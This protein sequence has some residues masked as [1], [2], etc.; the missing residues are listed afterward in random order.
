MQI[1]LIAMSTLL[2]SAARWIISWHPKQALA[3]SVS[4]LPATSAL[5]RWSSSKISVA[6]LGSNGEKANGVGPTALIFDTETTGMV[7]FRDPYNDPSQPDLVQLGFLMVDTSDWRIRNQ[8][9]FLVQLRESAGVGI[10]EGA[11]RVHG[12]SDQDCSDFGIK[13]ETAID[14]FENLCSKADFL[15]GHNIRFDAIV[16]QTAFYRSQRNSED[17]SFCDVLESKKQICTMIESIDLCKLPSKTHPASYK[18]PS[19]AEAYK[20]VTGGDKGEEGKSLEGAHDALVDSEACLQ[21]FRYLVEHGHVSLESSLVTTKATDLERVTE[22]SSSLEEE[23]ES[24]TVSSDDLGNSVISASFDRN[25]DDDRSREIEE[26][27]SHHLHDEDTNEI[28]DPSTET[29][30]TTVFD[31]ASFSSNMIET[32]ANR[33]STGDNG[34]GFRVR[35]NTYAHKEMIKQLG[36]RWNSQGK[37]WVFREGR[38]LSKLE[39]FDDLTIVPFSE[40]ELS[41][42]NGEKNESGN[43]QQQFNLSN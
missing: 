22:T 30:T 25:G 41:R 24:L 38:Y 23:S 34:E 19:L 27:A 12:I 21:I 20:F 43:D 6:A 7:R 26:A 9:S 42:N 1:K 31:P 28:I 18:W 32:E 29:E 2:T 14:L 36:G 37:E 35:G 8:G 17:S 13:H 3:F 11:Q 4:P 39:S 33:T 15:V 10:E 5:A 40:E 16:M